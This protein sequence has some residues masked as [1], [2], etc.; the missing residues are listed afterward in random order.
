MTKIYTTLESPIDLRK[1]LL[2]SNIKIIEILEDMENIKELRHNKHNTFLFLLAY[3]K[4]IQSGINGL[5][6]KFPHIAY[7]EEEELKKEAE[8]IDLEFQ[9]YVKPDKETD[10]LERELFQLRE[11]LKE[12]E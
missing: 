12:V 4:E 9:G 2:N 5:R 11:K 10:K 8:K 6:M 7:S 3:M 1:D